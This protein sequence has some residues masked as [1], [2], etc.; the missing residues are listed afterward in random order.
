MLLLLLLLL[1]LRLLLLGMRLIWCRHTWGLLGLRT[2]WR[3]KSSLIRIHGLTGSIKP[4]IGLWPCLRVHWGLATNRTRWSSHKHSCCSW[5]W[6]TR[7]RCGC[8][9][10]LHIGWNHPSNCG[11]WHHWHWGESSCHHSSH[12]LPHFARVIL[13]SQILL[14]KTVG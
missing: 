11:I 8:H 4:S 6:E 13:L 3:S 7:C 14:L 12:L 10:C 1:L 9:H 5:I 2:G